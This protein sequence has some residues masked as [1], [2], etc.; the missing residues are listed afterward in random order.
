MWHVAHL[1][2]GLMRASTTATAEVGAFLLDV[3]ETTHA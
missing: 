1:H 2:A 3:M